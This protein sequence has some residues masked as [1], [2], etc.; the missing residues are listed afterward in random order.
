M[1]AKKPENE[2]DLKIPYTLSLDST[3]IE[4]LEQ[5]G[6]QVQ[7][8][9]S[10]VVRRFLDHIDAAVW[11][12]LESLSSKESPPGMLANDILREKLGAGMGEEGRD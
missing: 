2:G 3:L 8:R 4:K 11:L 9:P 6:E 1:S 10:S 7:R 12:K 5:I